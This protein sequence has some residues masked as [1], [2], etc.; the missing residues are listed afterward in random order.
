MS[1]SAATSALSGPSFKTLV[2]KP[3]RINAHFFR[4]YLLRIFYKPQLAIYPIQLAIY[5]ID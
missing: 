3:T 2:T 5:L 1:L 4:Y